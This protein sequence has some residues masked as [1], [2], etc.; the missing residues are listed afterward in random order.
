MS[1]SGRRYIHLP[2]FLTLFFSHYFGDFFSSVDVFT[3]KAISGS[4]KTQ[5][6]EKKRLRY[7]PNKHYVE[8]FSQVYLFFEVLASEF[9]AIF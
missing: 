8:N 9:Q 5:K 6:A 3:G 7:S 4:K 1:C 2:T